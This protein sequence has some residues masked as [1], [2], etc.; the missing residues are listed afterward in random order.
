MWDPGNDGS[1]SRKQLQKLS[2]V[3]GAKI[4]YSSSQQ[5]LGD[6]RWGEMDIRQ[7]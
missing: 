7:E 6:V 2:H 5:G 3:A 1:N 4:N